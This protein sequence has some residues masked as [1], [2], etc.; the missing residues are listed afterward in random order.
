[1]ELTGVFQ[2]LPFLI[3]KNVAAPS[4]LPVIEVAGKRVVV[5]GGGDSAMD[6][7]RTA[8]RC[9]ASESLCLYRR[10]LANMPGSRKEY[11]NALEEGATFRFLTA[12]LLIEAE[13]GKV[14]QIRCVQ[15]ELGEP[16]AN[17]R[18]KPRPM[19]GSEFAVPTDIVLIA[20]GFDPVPFPPQSDLPGLPSM[21]GAHLSSMK[22]R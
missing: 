7:L 11:T 21:T 22:T 12:P 4:S 2:G 10:D 13:N 14:K 17:G 18:R 20:Y 16:D 6:C 19:K 5:L 9:G 1:M 8:I 3:Q 15:M